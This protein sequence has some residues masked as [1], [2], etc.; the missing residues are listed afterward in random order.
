MIG[1]DVAPLVAPVTASAVHAVEDALG[2][3]GY[4]LTLSQVRDTTRLPMALSR[5]DVDGLILHGN[6]PSEDLAVRLRQFPAVWMMSPRSTTG[7]WGDRVG[8][9]NTA[10]GQLAAE[11]LINRG[12]SRIAFL[13]L[14]VAHLG[15][16]E[17]IAAFQQ[18]AEVNRVANDVIRTEMRE[19]H[20]PGDFRN[21]RALISNLIDRF[22]SLPDRPTGLFV[23]RGQAI[24]MVFDALRSHDIEPG[25]DVTIIA[26]DNDPTLAGL[27]PQIA[28]IDVRPDRIVTVVDDS[29][30]DGDRAKTGVLDTNWWTSS[31]SSGDEISVGSLGLV[32]GTSGRGLHTVFAPQTLD[33]VGDK[34]TVSF[35][36]TTPTTVG[37]GSNAFRVGLFDSLG[38]AGLDADVSASSGTPNALY[39]YGTGAGGPGSQKLPGFVAIIDVNNGAAS[40]ISFREHTQSTL[41]GSGRLLATTSGFDTLGSSGPDEGDLF[42]ASTQY[43]GELMVERISATEFEYTYTIAG[44]SH[45]VIDDSI[46]SEVFD[47]LGFHANSNIFGS[48]GTAGEPDN[49][50]DFSNA[51]ESARNMQC[52]SNLRGIGTAHAIYG[53]DNK[54]DIVPYARLT[55]A[56]NDA[57]WFE[58]LATVM[59]S[60]RRDAAS[61]TT[62]IDFLRDEFS[63]PAFDAE[64]RAGTNTTKVG[65]GMNLRVDPEADEEYKPVDSL[66]EGGVG[67][68]ITVWRQYDKIRNPSEFIINGDSYEPH[69][70]ANLSSAADEPVPYDLVKFQPVLDDSKL[71]APTS[72]PALIPQGG[73]PGQSNQYFYLDPTGQYMTFQVSGDSNRSELRQE[74][75]TDWQTSTTDRLSLDGRVRLALPGTQTP[76]QYTFMQIHDTG[77]GLNKPLI[78]LTWQRERDSIEDHLWAAIRTPDDFGQPI[79]DDNLDTLSVDLGARPTGFFDASIVV[80]NNQMKVLIDGQVKVDMDVSY[81]DGLDNYFKA[82]VYLQDPGEV[83]VEFDQ[84]AYNVNVPE[85]ASL[86]LLVHTIEYV[87]IAVYLLLLIAIGVVVKRF[88]K[89]DSDYFR[90]GCKGTWW[91]V[92]ASAFMVQFSAWTFTGAAGAAYEAG[93][94]VMI[95][96]LANAAGY[97]VAGVVFAPWFRQLRVVTVPEAIRARFGPATQQL[98]AWIFVVLGLAYASLWLFGL[99]IFCSAVFGYK[100][101]HVVIVIGL[102]VL[103]YST[104][105]GS[106]AVMSTDFLQTLIL[107][108][109]TILMAYLCLRELG[110]VGGLF[111][112]IDEK[113]LAE[114]YAI[115]NEAG[116]FTGK[117]TYT[118]VWASAI[119]LAQIVKMNTVMASQRYYAVKT[120]LDAR[121]AALLAGFLMVMGSLIWFIPPMTGRLLFE[122]DVMGVLGMDEGKR[123]EASYAITS[124]KLL[125]AGMTGL[126]VVAMLSATMSSMDSGLNKNAAMLVRDIIPALARLFGI[127]MDPNK[128][129]LLMAQVASFC[130]GVAIIGLTLYFVAQDGKGVFELMLDIGAML[131]LPMAVPMLL[132]LLIRRAPGWSAIASITVGFSVSAIGFYSDDLFG[133]KW[134]FA[135]VVFANMSAATVGFVLTI[136]LWPTASQAYREKVDGF[137]VRMHKPIDFETEVG[138]GNDLSQLNIMGTFAVIIG[139]FIC[140]LVLIDNPLTGRLGILF[141][142]GFVGLV[143]L[144]FMMI[145]RRA[146]SLLPL[147]VL[148]AD[149]PQEAGEAACGVVV[150]HEARVDL[151]KHFGGGGLFTVCGRGAAGDGIDPQINDDLVGRTVVAERI[152]VDGTGVVVL[153]AHTDLGAGRRFWHGGLVA[154]A[155]RASRVSVGFLSGQAVKVRGMS[156]TED[157]IRKMQL[158]QDLEAAMEECVDQD[159]EVLV[160]QSETAT[161]INREARRYTEKHGPTRLCVL[162]LR[163]DKEVVGAMA[164]QWPVDHDITPGEVESLRLTANL[165][166][167]RLHQFHLD[168]QWIGARLARSMRKGVAAIVGPKHTWAKLT[169]IAASAF[170]AFLLFAKGNDT[171]DA[172]FTVQTTKRQ[173]ITAP[174]A[175]TLLRVGEGVEVDAAVVGVDAAS[176]Q[177]PSVLAVMDASELRVERAA[178]DAELADY[179]AQ[180]DAARGEGDLSA[181]EVAMSNVSR[182]EAQARLLDF[183]IERS[184]LTSPMSG[185]VLEGDLRQ[186]INGT[187]EKGEVVFEIAPLDALRAELRVPASRIG[188]LRSRRANPENPSRGELASASHPGAFVG[189]VVERIEPEA[190]VVDGQNV[191][192]VRVE[193]DRVTD[194]LRPGVEGEARVHVARR[195]YGY[196]WTRDAVN[197]SDRQ[198]YRGR[199]WIVLRDPMTNKFYRLDANN[200]KMIG[201][202]DGRRTVD[203]AWKLVSEQ[204]GHDAPTQGEIIQLLGQLYTNNLVEAD[205]PAD[206][207]GMFDRY[208]K[209]KQREVRGYL[210]SILFARIPLFDPDRILDRVTPVLG[211]LFGPVGLLLWLGLIGYALFALAGSGRADMIIG[212]ALGDPASGME[213]VLA[214]SNL[215][216][217][218]VGMLIVKLLHEL[219]HGVACKRFGQ[220]RHTGGEV[221]TVGVM[222]IAFIPIPYV[223]ASSSWSL[224]SKWHRAFIAAA[225]MYVELAVAAVALLVWVQ[226]DVHSALHQL[227]YNII[228]IASVT[229]LLF[230][231]N[232]LI[233][234]DGYYIL[235]DLIEMPNLAQRSKDYLYY[236]VKRFAYKVRQP[237]NPSH[238][239][240]E[241]PVLVI[242]GVLSFFYR[243]FITVTIVWFVMDK[244]FFIGAAMAVMAI[245]GFA[246]VPIVKLIKYLATNPELTR[247]RRRSVA[248]SAATA[249]GL[250][251]LFGVLPIPEWKTAPGLVE[252]ADQRE[253][254]V[255]TEG[256]LVYL[257]PTGSQI[258]EAD[259]VI[260]RSENPEL[261]TERETINARIAMLN[262]QYNQR[263]A[264]GQNAAAVAVGDQVAA[265]EARLI[266]L[267]RREANLTLRAPFPGR[268]SSPQLDGWEGVYAQAGESLG[269]LVNDETLHIVVL[270]DQNIGPRLRNEL[271]L[272]EPVRVR[273]R[274]EPGRE[275]VGTITRFIESGQQRLPSPALGLGG[276]GEMVTD[277]DD[278]NAQ[279]TARAYFEVHLD[280]DRDLAAA[281]GYRPGQAVAARFSLPSR[282]IASQA[283]RKTPSPDVQHQQASATQQAMGFDIWRRLAYTAPVEPLPKGLDAWWHGLAGKAR[284][285]RPDTARLLRFADEV[286]RASAK[287]K[288]LGGRALKEQIADSHTLFRRRRDT[289]EAQV[290]AFAQIREAARRTLAM[291]PYPVQL[292]AAKGLTER[293]FVE[294]AT[295]EGKTLVGALPSVIAGWRGRGCHVLTVNDYLAGRDADLMSPLYKF[296]GL[297]VSALTEEMEPPERQ[298]AYASDITY[299]TNKSVTADYLRDKLA[300]GR[301]SGLTDALLAKRLGESRFLTLRGTPDVL[302]MRSL[303]TV[304]IDEAD[305][306]LIDEA[307]T[308]L[309]ISVESQDDERIASFAVAADL[310]QKLEEGEHFKINRTYREID[311]TAR[312]RRRLAEACNSLQGYWQGARLREELVNQALSARH[313]F[314]R[315]QHYVID[316]G[317]VVIVDE[318]TGR[319]MPDRSWRA[320]LH[321]AVEAK[322]GLE[323]TAPKETL[324]RISFQRFFRGYQH[325]SGMSGTGWESRRELWHN[326]KLVTTRLPTH[327]PC[328]RVQQPERVFASRDEKYDMMIQE[329]R[330]MHQSGR[331]V[332]IGTRSVESSEAI[333]QMLTRQGL[334][335]QV[336][337]AVRHEQEAAIVADAGLQGAITVATNMAGRGTDIKLGRGVAKLGGLHVICAE[338]N[339]SKRIDRQLFGRAGRQGD[340]GSAVSY[341]SFEDTLIKCYATKAMRARRGVKPFD[342]A[343]RRAQA[344]GR[345]QRKQVARTDEQL[346]EQLGF[347]GREH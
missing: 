184:V 250:V 5:G 303:D 282:P 112:K 347:A 234:F 291:E 206:A 318:S 214:P 136:P 215:W 77:A 84:L 251:V 60:E 109:I 189:F 64:A 263:L 24:L 106:W 269:R 300:L 105:G 293:R 78:R 232:P 163:L 229:T 66:A 198:H 306:I 169:A 192:R 253:L 21:Q 262:A 340:T 85:P 188:D 131:A 226:T 345:A 108:P 65:Y 140:S 230:N 2:G 199:R 249:C 126:M 311:F 145:A 286:C 271:K 133:E 307:V 12:H 28:T 266:D 178:L 22:A 120:G 149:L 61:P 15:I 200:Y 48:S 225:G 220:R 154:E 325:L 305:S 93:W 175:G 285:L 153:H 261:A 26:C 121:K 283:Y 46:D 326:Y 202:L 272:G 16:P 244:L 47:F 101:E 233:R 117:N 155:W 6:P 327:R 113:G 92:G 91:L 219:G 242:Y 34:L 69:L 39:G 99:S 139:L 255:Q 72:S 338:R 144:L 245:V 297:N 158:V 9:D 86:L 218:Y 222:L 344:I 172:S 278:P 10:I 193:L 159:S 157:V 71:Q 216:L 104:V 58:D 330:A 110:G 235:S 73:F 264:E 231:A 89:D 223:D 8:P 53:N 168:D 79:A 162:P 30:A 68:D 301:L 152:G 1:T 122:A 98:Y 238:G 40:D 143:G 171:V 195:S 288:D 212:Q 260:A 56:G 304:I 337:N 74:T 7:Y 100:V 17:R 276:G 75:G 96:F 236:L 63:C 95:I 302:M 45:S 290:R 51:R 138:Q 294:L 279:Q 135:T 308:P 323:V 142:G 54:Q 201:L 265:L 132:A 107:I 115:V 165:F 13:N 314:L 319:L 182:V 97:L 80:Q 179:H 3:L 268:W 70:K 317:K 341:V 50:I 59:I 221:H 309:I 227:A 52:L 210:A 123:K 67:V 102:I 103:V 62:R 191:F 329:V 180:A 129:R 173:V 82:G 35:T 183:R 240:A 284:H 150:E 248:W 147:I 156:H 207:A 23:P 241:R 127:K 281:A 55:D 267:D 176:G 187:L 343:Q 130:F 190:E 237:H 197:W 310:A 324:A 177:G 239:L 274:G 151:K 247:T 49:G 170:V 118:W 217:L 88:N 166:T 32:T 336:L 174:F 83:A 25:K 328:I 315:D 160:P 41:D 333:S 246:I 257:M 29:F 209:R 167:A 19:P 296:C 339:D 57:Y 161:T 38:Q 270:A 87:V 185:V 331:P 164:V 299:C 116:R 203:Q 205:L 4:S 125:P 42:A 208:K 228:F 18:T 342:L 141:V 44:A 252:A 259:R 194:W 287:L 313:L 43:N 128:P 295:G 37:G 332:L 280:V 134:S 27:I 256:Q 119:F 334:E 335:H 292:A 243:I 277:P 224:R 76:E 289:H 20:H 211:W 322:E 14:D 298:A 320:G 346:N 94:S 148:L 36:F 186:R 146:K 111:E 137:F 213:G 81:W 124:L 181:V 11:Y 273:L 321:Q 275:V 196:L 258:V 312:G 31:S 204:L 114:D 90:N 254:F 316:E 33:D